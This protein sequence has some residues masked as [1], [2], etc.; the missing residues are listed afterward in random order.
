[1]TSMAPNI[2]TQLWFGL[3]YVFCG[4]VHG[5]KSSFCGCSA[6]NRGGRSNVKRCVYI[7]FRK[8]ETDISSRMSRGKLFHKRGAATTNDE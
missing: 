6:I 4:D 3:E 8:I 2:A 7:S 1:M 5:R